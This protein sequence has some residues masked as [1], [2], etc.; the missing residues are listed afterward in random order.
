[1]PSR[2]LSRVCLSLVPFLAAVLPLFGQPN[3][4]TLNVN[5]TFDG[6]VGN[7]PFPESY[8]SSVTK[9]GGSVSLTLTQTNPV[10]PSQGG[11]A[12]ITVAAPGGALTGTEFSSYL[13]GN[14]AFVFDNPVTLQISSTFTNSNDFAG[15]TLVGYNKSGTQVSC[16]AT[17]SPKK[18]TATCAIQTLPISTPVS[19]GATG[20]FPRLLEQSFHVFY[21]VHGSNGPDARLVIEYDYDNGCGTSANEHSSAAPLSPRF[22]VCG[23]KISLGPAFPLPGTTILIPGAG[24]QGPATRSPEFVVGR[25]D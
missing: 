20:D 6:K 13:G 3:T 14:P 15:F 11:T 18:P 24:Q 4:V 25:I 23:N 2:I 7:A 8:S 21:N 17:L 5:Q 22:G 9:T 12:V 10:L 1:M 19:R 16:D